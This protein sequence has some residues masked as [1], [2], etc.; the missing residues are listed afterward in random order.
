MCL[1]KHKCT[2]L[3]D[4]LDKEIELFKLNLP[5]HKFY[6]GIEDDTEAQLDFVK[7][8]AGIIRQMYCYWVC[9]N[10]EDCESIE[11]PH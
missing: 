10:K 4:F 9:K 8:Y 5:L 1:K 7:K 6:N 11:I 2:E 3:K